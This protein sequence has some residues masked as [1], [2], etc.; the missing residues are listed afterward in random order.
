MLEVTRK[1]IDKIINESNK[2]VIIS[3]VGEWC[4]DCNAVTP[5]YEKLSREYNDKLIFGRAHVGKEKSF[6]PQKFDFSYIP[7]FIIF[8]NG[9]VWKRLTDEEEIGRVEEEIKNVIQASS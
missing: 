5:L 1:N 3:F 7:T 4:P 2:P 8:R 6:W 9:K